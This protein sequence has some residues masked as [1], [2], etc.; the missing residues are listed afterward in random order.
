M[1]HA[2]NQKAKCALQAWYLETWE[3]RSC[4]TVYPTAV[5]ASSTRATIEAHHFFSEAPHLRRL[6]PLPPEIL[7]FTNLLEASTARDFG[8]LK[9]VKTSKKYYLFESKKQNFSYRMKN[10]MA[11]E[12][13]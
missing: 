6:T 7:F 2:G 1:L 12:Y 8:A 11:Y 3:R 10:P 9:R 5:P 4:R 13:L